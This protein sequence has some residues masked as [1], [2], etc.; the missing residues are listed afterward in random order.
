V[1][2][3][4]TGPS[5]APGIQVEA[6]SNAQLRVTLDSNTVIGNVDGG[7]GLF[8]SGTGTATLFAQVRLNTLTG[9]G[10]LI[11]DLDANIFPGANNTRIC[12]QPNNN[13]IGTFNRRNNAAGTSEIQIEG[14]LPGTNTITSTPA[15]IGN[16]TTVAAGTCGF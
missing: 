4:G 11:G 8:T 3:N 9:N 14:A 1:Q 15:A 6:Q 13:T 16:V 12:I 7:V 10:A 5:F 2:G